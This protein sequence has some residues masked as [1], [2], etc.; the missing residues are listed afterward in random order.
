MTE[1]PQGN[2]AVAGQLERG[3]R[4]QLGERHMTP[5]G[6]EILIHCHVSA[7]PHPRLGAP[8]VSEELFSLEANGL[9]ERCAT[10]TGAATWK[11]T[12]KGAAHVEQLCRTAWPTQAWIGADG[13]V[14]KFDA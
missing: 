5:N 11:T 4:H 8:A 9:I 3:V 1:E 6:I 13:T 7:A 14:L 2:A 10:L 12:A